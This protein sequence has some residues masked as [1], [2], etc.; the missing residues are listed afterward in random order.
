MRRDGTALFKCMFWV[1]GVRAQMAPLEKVPT[2]RENRAHVRLIRVPRTNASHRKATLTITWRAGVDVCYCFVLAH[3]SK[4]RC[5]RAR[6]LLAARN[7][8]GIIRNNTWLVHIHIST[9]SDIL[10]YFPTHASRNSRQ[11]SSANRNRQLVQSVW[12]WHRVHS[13]YY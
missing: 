12:N 11:S 1:R 5:Q 13:L 4:F 9:S 10:E 3:Y 7:A 6:F 8:S 2:H